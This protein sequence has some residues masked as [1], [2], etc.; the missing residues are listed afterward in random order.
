[1]TLEEITLK[2]IETWRETT[3]Q[4]AAYFKPA[5]Q[6]L[7][8][9]LLDAAERSIES[10][11]KLAT[12]EIAFRNLKEGFDKLEAENKILKEALGKYA[13]KNNYTVGGV[14]FVLIGAD[15]EEDYNTENWK[16]AS[17]VLEKLK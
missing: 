7:V 16:F 14:G 3:L 17:D 9:K 6:S 15:G 12:T 2:N 8:L 4:D 11:K 13:D 1:M 10:D 5:R